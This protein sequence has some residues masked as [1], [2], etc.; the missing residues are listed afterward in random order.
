MPSN[1]VPIAVA[2]IWA[3][4]TLGI[5]AASRRLH[6]RFAAWWSSPLLITWTACL[7]LLIAS[8]TSYEDYLSGTNWLIAL[9]GPTTVAFAVPIYEQRAL[10]RRHG[11]VLL[12][13]VVVG[14]ALSIACSWLLASLLHLS[15][16]LRASLLPRSIT[17]P[18]AMMASTNIGGVP[19][20]T[21]VFT[22]ITGLFGAAI[23]APLL[24]WL[25]IESGLA[26]SALLAMGAHGAGVSRAYQIGSAEGS[27]ASVVMV[28]AGLT[29]VILASLAGLI[30]N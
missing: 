21:A 12:V 30:L 19:E 14:S 16:E 18:L 27:V 9:L 10:I 15:P 1:L 17:T 29:N 3:A 26:K 22:A 20:L 24:D 5:Y 7:F 8:D 25:R 28:L 13:G 4:V 23:G 11:A 2:L 6:R